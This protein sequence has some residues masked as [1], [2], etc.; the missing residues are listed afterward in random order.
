MSPT[1]PARSAEQRIAALKHANEVRSARSRLKHAIRNG[2]RA[3]AVLLIREPTP[4]VASMRVTDLLGA[5]R[6]VGPTRITLLMRRCAIS[7][8]KTLGGLSH[9]QR[10]ALCAELE[11][12][13]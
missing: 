12:R 6:G 8:V 9:R 7:P 5:I 4:G 13:P 3:L 10:H 2:D 1:A 11:R